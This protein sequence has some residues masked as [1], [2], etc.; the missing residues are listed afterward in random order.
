MFPYPPSWCPPPPLVLLGKL[1]VFGFYGLSTVSFAHFIYYCDKD[2]HD[3]KLEEKPQLNGLAFTST[4]L[5][6]HRQIQLLD[7][8]NGYQSAQLQAPGKITSQKKRRKKG[9]NMKHIVIVY[10]MKCD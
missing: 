2:W 5:S 9:A 6:N 8:T 1:T 7:L 4:L 3:W 10:I